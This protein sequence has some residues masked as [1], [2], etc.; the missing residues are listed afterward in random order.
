MASATGRYAIG[1]V[2]PG[3]YALAVET[4]EG[5]R[6]AVASPPLA[7]RGGRLR[8]NLRLLE[9]GDEVSGALASTGEWWSGLS[10]AGKVWVVTGAT[11][12]TAIAI[13][14]LDDDDEVFASPSTP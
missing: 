12:L 14:G 13:A 1:G 4:P 2:P 7:V 11:A 3:T 5:T 6:A 9:Q 8:I 10:T